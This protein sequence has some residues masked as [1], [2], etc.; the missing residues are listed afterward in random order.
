MPLSTI[1]KEVKINKLAGARNIDL[2]AE[3]V[4]LYGAKGININKEALLSLFK[5]ISREV[6]SITFNH[7]SFASVL[8]AKNIIRELTELSGHGADKP[9]FPQVGLESGSPRIMRKYMSGKSRPW[10][11]EEWPQVVKEA[12]SI[13]N[14]NYWYPCCTLIIGFPDETE[15]DIIRT[16]ELVDDLRSMRA[17]A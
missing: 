1:M 5:R 13:M 6:P 11:P 17:K 8:P 10:R 12:M 15:D 16:L 4:M 9:L 7:A 14:E 2:I 3:D